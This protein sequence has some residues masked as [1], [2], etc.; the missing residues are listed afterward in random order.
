MGLW[1]FTLHNNSSLLLTDFQL[2]TTISTSSSQTRTILEARSGSTQ[3]G[4]PGF[5]IGQVGKFTQADNTTP[6]IGD[7]YI[8][9]P[10]PFVVGTPATANTTPYNT[11]TVN[12]T[13]A[14]SGRMN[15][16]MF[17]CAGKVNAMELKHS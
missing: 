1:G 15:G 4:V 13:M 2:R 10:K 3:R 6:Y 12:G 11:L 14:C 8:Y 16:N 17:F 9:T 5:R 7:N